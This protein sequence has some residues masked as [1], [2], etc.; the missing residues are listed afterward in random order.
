MSLMV[1]YVSFLLQSTSDF[2]IQ[3]EE[4]SIHVHK[5]ILKIRCQYYRNMFKHNWEENN[6]K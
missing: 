1:L 4:Q 6:Q 5:A 3:V 2:T